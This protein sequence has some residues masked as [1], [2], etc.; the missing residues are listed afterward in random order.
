MNV[1]TFHSFKVLTNLCVFYDHNQFSIGKIFIISS[2]EECGILLL[3]MYVVQQFVAF[4]KNNL[5]WGCVAQN[6]QQ[7]KFVWIGLAFFY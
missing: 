2:K 6:F 5:R 1:N 7:I 4:L 3:T